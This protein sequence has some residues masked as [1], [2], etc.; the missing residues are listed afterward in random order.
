MATPTS[1]R[2]MRRIG[3][4]AVVIAVLAILR[5]WTVRPLQTAP[6]AAFDATAYVDQAWPRLLDEASR[7]AVDVAE[8]RRLAAQPAATGAP[9]RRS[10]FV[11][12]TG[13]VTAVER[14]SRVGLARLRTDERPE[15]E[16]GVQIGPV[17]RG[18]ALRDAATFIR[19]ND[20]ANQF[21]FAAVSNALHERALRDVVTR[22]D[23]DTAVGQRVTV[24]GAATLQAGAPAD[25]PIDLVPIDIRVQG[26]NR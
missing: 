26:A 14:R 24:I 12:V 17:V 6:A 8:A 7:T 19:F 4:P 11:K 1:R 3:L 16:V 23:L 9:G 20:F 18:T 22:L 25:A 5:P 21:E 10:L 2:W 13:G 15:G